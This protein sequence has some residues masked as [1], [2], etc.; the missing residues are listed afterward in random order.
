LLISQIVDA[1]PSLLKENVVVPF[2]R[3]APKLDPSYKLHFQPP[4]HVNVIGS[5]PLGTSIKTGEAIEIDM[6]VTMPKAIFQEKDYLNFRYFCKRSY[7]LACLAAGLKSSLK[8]SYRIAFS[9]LDGITH[10]PVV[11]VTSEISA[12]AQEVKVRIIPELPQGMFPEKRLRP[13]KNCVRSKVSSEDDAEKE[14][15]AFYNGSIMCD[16]LMTPYMKLQHDSLRN[17]EAYREANML[18]RIWLRQRGLRGRRESGGFGNFEFAAITALLLQGGGPKNAPAFSPGYSSYQMFKATLQYLAARDLISNPHVVGVA[19]QS[20]KGTECPIFFD[21]TRQHNLLYKMTPWS[22]RRLQNEARTTNKALSD[23][24]FDQFDSTFIMRAENSLCRYDVMIEIANNQKILE[25]I[26]N[27]RLNISSG[28]QELYQ[29]L[30]KALSNRV[31]RIYL[32]EP[33]LAPWQVASVLPASNEHG[34]LVIGFE[35][36]PHNIDRTIDNGPLVSMRKEAEEFRKFWDSKAELRRFK[37]GTISESVVW[38]VSP[39]SP[40]IF[41]QIVSLSL[42]Q[43]FGVELEQNVRYEESSAKFCLLDGPRGQSDIVAFQPVM[44]ALQDLERDIR[45]IE[46]LPLHLRIIQAS[47]SKLSYS[48]STVPF[49]SGARIPADVIVQFEGSARWPDD[50]GAIHRTKAAMLLKVAESLE[51]SQSR[52]TCRVGL[53]N[54]GDELLNQAFLD[55]QYDTGICFRLRIHHDREATLLERQLQDKSASASQRTHAAGALA[56]YKRDYLHRPAHTQAMQGLAIRFPP[57]SRTVRLAKKWFSATLLRPHFADEA[58]ELLVAR[59]FTNAHP[60]PAPASP[61]TGLLRLLVA[62]A[63]WDWRSEPWVVNVGAEAMSE[64]DVANVSTRFQAWRKL[65]PALNRV[66][67]F[68]ASNIDTDGDTWTG[69]TRPAKVIAARLTEL[70]KSAVQWMAGAEVGFSLEPLFA[71]DLSDYDF[72]V[73]INEDFMHG[74]RKRG[75]D[76]ARFKNLQLQTQEAAAA[77]PDV[78]TLFVDELTTIYHATI[79]LFSG[80]ER[81]DFIAGLWIPHETR[82]WKLKLGYSSKPVADQGSELTVEVNR[83]AILSEIARLGG[84]LIRS[85]EVRE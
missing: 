29:T 59:V 5:Y 64:G 22:Y 4:A 49:K 24:A 36:D 12:K 77:G 79:L 16:S 3:E 6:V 56:T 9:S 74:S 85:I 31:A 40:S 58:I 83:E 28:Y 78:L 63:R 44:L 75:E 61:R 54:E 69:H 30:A 33:E 21:G 38:D 80:E 71:V 60:W 55:A 47:D 15:T 67:L 65:D 7:Y 8:R 51:E 52:I 48:S 10:S 57:F 66:V 46:D 81:R 42:R 72:V 32:H 18:G 39:E 11:V 1:A 25:R 20:I 13:S 17:F 50:L 68:I 41:Y 35:Y 70:A 84:D 19:G 2:P 37:D 27:P 43:H 73:H 76:E 34:K 23:T 53:E 45:A 62:L 26:Y 14:P 82:T